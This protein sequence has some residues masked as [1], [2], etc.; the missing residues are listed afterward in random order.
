MEGK[1]F[2]AGI[3][4]V[5]TSAT[6]K[7][8][9]EQAPNGFPA[10]RS[11]ECPDTATKMTDTDTAVLPAPTHHYLRPSARGKFIFIGEEKL[12][13]RGVT[14]GT[15]RPDDDGHAADVQLVIAD[16]HELAPC[17]RSSLYF[18]ERGGIVRGDCRSA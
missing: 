12:Y 16:E 9:S 11:M 14:Y 3:Q 1:S 8:S 4:P 5:H 7:S 15:F 13:V 17:G 2:G 6:T 10:V 18:R